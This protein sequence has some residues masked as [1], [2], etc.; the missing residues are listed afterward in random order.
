MAHSD[1]TTFK[2]GFRKSPAKCQIEA[3]QLLDIGEDSRGLGVGGSQ[4]FLGTR[5]QFGKTEGSGH[6]WW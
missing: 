1:H 3:I 6:G 4:S 5:F 2:I